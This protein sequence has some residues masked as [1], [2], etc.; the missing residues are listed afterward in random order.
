MTARRFRP[1]TPVLL[2]VIRFFGRVIVTPFCF[3]VGREPVPCRVVVSYG[4]GAGPVD[5]RELKVE[6]VNFPM[7]PVSLPLAVGFGV[8]VLGERSVYRRSGRHS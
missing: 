6:S 7:C 2:P 1:G 5:F 8:R 3:T 4:R